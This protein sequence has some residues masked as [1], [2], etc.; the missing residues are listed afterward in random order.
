[1]VQSTKNKNKTFCRFEQLFFTMRH[2]FKAL[3]TPVRVWC[4]QTSTQ[5]QSWLHRFLPTTN[6]FPSVAYEF[7]YEN[8]ATTILE[9][10]TFQN[11]DP[12]SV[13][14]LTILMAAPKSKV[15]ELVGALQSHIIVLL[16]SFQLQ[17][18][19]SRK[20]QKH[21]RFIPD[22]V[23][24]AKCDR[25]GEPKRPH[26]ICSDHA[27]ICAMRPEEYEAHKQKE[28]NSSPENQQQKS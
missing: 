4:A 8:N 13:F 9:N 23:P 5:L 2:L 1:M 12:S 3:Q 19:P 10:D 21:M 17:I 11:N 16:F 20:R 7:A 22:P 6:N 26:R 14:D 15:S 27:D 24:W 28:K 18:S 25:C